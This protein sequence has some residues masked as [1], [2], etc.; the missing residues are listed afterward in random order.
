MHDLR[1][2]TALITGA[3]SGL[4]RELAFA[5]AREEAVVL[6]V[7][8]DEPALVETSGLLE[9]MGARNRPYVVDVSDREQVGAMAVKVQEEFGGLDVLIN[10]AGVF[11]WADF[12]DTTLEDWEWLMGV[13]LWGPILT[14]NAFL[15]G[16]IERKSGHIVNIASLG[17]LVTMPTLSGYSTT[18]FGLVGLTETLQH[19][20]EPHGIAVTLVCPGN[21]R[22]PIVDH[23]KVRGYNREKLTKMSY[24]VMPRMSADKAAAIILKGMKKGRSLVI[25]TP[26]AHFMYLV[27][28]L[29][30]NLYRVMLGRPMRKVYERMR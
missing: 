22:T 19:E 23:I 11:V 28:R 30:P 12:A 10:N 3:A 1:G 6:L 27:K 16:M 4:G 20:L 14:I 9:G 25:L 2:K 21:I 5:L 18:K 15:P 26:M 7:D 8:V 17:G 29:S 13:N 24:G